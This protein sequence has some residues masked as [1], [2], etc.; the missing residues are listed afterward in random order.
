MEHFHTVSAPLPCVII[1]GAEGT[2]KTTFAMSAPGPIYVI[3]TEEGHEED[4]ISR[5]REDGKDV[6]ITRFV[7]E[8]ADAYPAIWFG[9]YKGLWEQ[10]QLAL[11]ELETLPQGTVVF[12]SAS[13]L[14]G[15]AAAFFNITMARGDKPIP[16]LAYTQVYPLL[17]DVINRLR[18]KHRIALTIRLKDEWVNNAQTGGQVLNIWKDAEY[19]AEHIIKLELNRD[20]NVVFAVGYK[21]ISDGSIIANPTWD[22]VVNVEIDTI[23]GKDDSKL[24]VLAQRLRKAWAYLDA[25]NFEYE[26]RIVTDPVLLEAYIGELRAIATGGSQAPSTNGTAVT[27]NNN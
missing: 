10:M 20:L 26:K 12:D 24:Y 19:L 23:F 17:R 5:V 14:F 2:R 27:S 3:G 13:D 9:S 7:R 6:F 21:G 11:A 4:T 16:P 1:A 15:M 8:R 22:K 18:G 25:H